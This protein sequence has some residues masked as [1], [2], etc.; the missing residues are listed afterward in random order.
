MQNFSRRTLE[1]S[2][3]LEFDFKK[4]PGGF[5]G[6]LGGMILCV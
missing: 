4:D 5:L 6:G 2:G 1:D 3:W